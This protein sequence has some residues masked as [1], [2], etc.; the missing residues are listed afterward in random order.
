[1]IKPVS[2][3]NKFE[4]SFPSRIASRLPP[5]FRMAQPRKNFNSNLPAACF[6]AASSLLGKRKDEERE[7]P[8]APV[9][10]LSLHLFHILSHL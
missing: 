10:L 6:V 3:R 7:A 5:L 4:V 9:P 1:M 8:P 2:S